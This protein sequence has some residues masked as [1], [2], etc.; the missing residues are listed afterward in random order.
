MRKY[1][2]FLFILSFFLLGA[3]TQKDSD[4]SVQSKPHKWDTLK[5]QKFDYVLIVGFYQQYRNFNNDIKQLIN[6][7]TMALSQHVYSAESNLVSGLAFNYDKFQLSFGIRSKPQDSS[8]GK[9]YTKMFNLGFSF[10][11]NRWVSENYFRKFTGFYDKSTPSYDSTFKRTG[12][13][14]LQPNLYNSL[15]MSR[16]MYFTNF[17][18]FSY[19]AGFGCNYRQLKSAATWILG[20]SVNAYNLQ[21]DSSIIPIQARY[22]Y[23]DYAG[24]KG[25]RSFNFGFNAGAAATLVLFKA[26]FITGY[27]TIGPEQQ[28]RTYNLGNT[29]RRL[30]Y[31]SWSGTGRFAIGLNLKRCYILGSYTNDYNLY[32]SKG[33]SITSNA[34]TGNFTFG[35][36]FHTGTPPKLYR[37]FQDTKLYKLF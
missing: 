2:A 31:V 5:Y 33:L 8:S 32:N 22:L 29:T 18:K 24:F 11:D 20:A 30:S 36:R 21:N 28:W 13:Y 19:K 15:F 17:K 26:W 23:N 16:L 34:V 1:L 37:K 12:N 35:W 27:F 9:G 4:I 14:Y 7:D 3:Q 6:R 10:G 25:L